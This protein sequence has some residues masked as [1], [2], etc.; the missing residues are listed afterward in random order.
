[1]K[2]NKGLVE[3]CKAQLGRPYWYGTFGHKASASLYRQKS[4]QYPVYYK[5]DDYV[6]QYGEKVHDCSG[7]IKGYLFCDTPDGFYTT[8]DSQ[9][10][11]GINLAN[12]TRQGIIADLPEIEGLLLFKPRTCWSL[13]RRRKSHRSQR[14]CLWSGRDKIK[15]RQLGNMGHDKMGRL[16]QERCGKIIPRGRRKR[17]HRLFDFGRA[18][19]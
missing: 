7:L 16:R 18:H 14:S 1:M 5:A 10:D 19:R 9:I 6:E 3:Y 13:H 11:G 8:Y 17:S 15:R 12:C 4:A 2:T